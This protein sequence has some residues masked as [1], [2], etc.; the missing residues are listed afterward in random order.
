[1]NF[2]QA[3][4]ILVDPQHEGGYVNDPKDPGGET[5]YGLSK[6]SFPGEDIKNLTL[7][8]AKV[9]YKNM[10]WGPA[11]CDAVPDCL[12]YQMFD[13]AVNCGVATAVKALQRAVGA[14]IDGK[15]GNET[16]L[17]V[18]SLPASS[19]LARFYAKIIQYYT[20]LPLDQRTRF[21]TGWMNRLA[22]NLENL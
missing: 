11:G 7:D 14:T 6:R 19:L 4:D 1:M 8:R 16:L 2:D 10:Y 18:S 3:F 13:T 15:L 5:K 12:K 21:L 9:I 17:R 22:A 20:S